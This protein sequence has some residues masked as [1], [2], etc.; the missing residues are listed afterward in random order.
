LEAE[1]AALRAKL[2]LPPKTPVNSS[3]PPSQGHKAKGESEP[4]PRARRIPARIARR[5]RIRRGPSAS[6]TGYASTFARA[7]IKAV[8]HRA[9]PRPDDVPRSEG[10]RAM[11]LLDTVEVYI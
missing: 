2:K 4:G 8:A 3:T 10:D 5:T 9:P 7:G 11:K 1:N 6:G